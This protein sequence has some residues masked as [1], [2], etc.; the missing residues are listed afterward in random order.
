MAGV[1]STLALVW[2]V[3]NSG[4]EEAASS[5]FLPLLGLAL[6]L[7]CVFEFVNGFHDTANAV[8]TVIYTRSLRPWVAVVWSGFCNFIGVFIGGI[9][10]AMGII[11]LLP[12]EILSSGNAALNLAMI[13]SMLLSAIAWNL[14]TWYYGIPASS[15]HTMIGAILGI[16]LGNA[17]L[18]GVPLV[19][20]INWSKA[21]DV[22][23]A[24]LVSPAIGFGFS[25]MGVYLLRRFRSRS[26]I[27][28][29]PRPHERAPWHVR[30]ALIATST[31]VSL[32]HGS[33][34]GQKGVG[35]I[36]L[37]LIAVL[38]TQFA[39]NPVLV[40]TP[41]KLSEF[42]ASIHRVQLALNDESLQDLPK[43]ASIHSRHE[44]VTKAPV[45]DSGMVSGQP[46]IDRLSAEVDATLASS[47][48]NGSVPLSERARLRNSLYSLDKELKALEK[49]FPQS[50]SVIREERKN[51]MKMTEYAPIWVLVMIAMSLGVGTM[52][53]WKRIVITIG[54]K[55]GKTHLTYAQGAVSE[56][57]A[58]STIGLSALAGVPV[59]T[60]HCL[61]SGIAGGMVASRSGI[62]FGMVRSMLIA[63]FLTLPVTILLSAGLFVSISRFYSL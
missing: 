25:A 59:S 20:G 26:R 36:M 37:I 22:G 49:K 45:S 38:P 52:I 35:L 3:F 14:G 48:Q 4:F 11:K 28:H 41:E 30:M 1:Y 53:G 62:H 17:H 33:N 29:A 55:I 6:L 21:G 12:A 40:G 23:A 47:I 27:H 57:V 16:G 54:E 8:A 39:L 2:S 51:L 46:S 34:D 56:L 5:G 9:A 10:V 50:A 61:S 44:V 58:M 42:R 31:G 19:E 43:V 15:S 63:W 18:R 24:L 60:T 7:A 13:F 32:A